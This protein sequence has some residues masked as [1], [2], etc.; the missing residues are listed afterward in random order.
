MNTS[1][2]FA[3]SVSSFIATTGSGL[4][5]A[6]HTDSGEW[7]VETLLV[8]QDVRCLAA[9]PLHPSVVYAGT[10]GQGVFRSDD[11]GAT[12]RPAGLGGRIIK[13]LAVSRTQPGVVYAGNKPALLFV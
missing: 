2:R 5:R 1:R 12:W 8:D 13:A 10:Q 3:M 7:H 4:T 6:T 11:R 9:D